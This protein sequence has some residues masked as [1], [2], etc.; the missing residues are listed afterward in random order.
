MNKKDKSVW[1]YFYRKAGGR[2]EEDAAPEM[3]CM[4]EEI[5]PLK[6]VHL[7][8]KAQAVMLFEQG[9]IK[10][11]HGIAILTA[12]KEMDDKGYENVREQTG[13]GGHSG[14]AFLI[15]KLGMETGGQ[16]HIGR[17]SAD[18]IAVAIRV[19]QRDRIIDILNQIIILNKTLIKLSKN[20]LESVIPAYTHFQQAQPITLAH[21]CMSWI[22]AFIRDFDR[23]LEI[24]PR[25]NTS[26]A[27]AAIVSGSPLP[28]NRERVAELIG[29]NT[30][31]PNT[32]DAIF[33]YDHHLEL[34]SKLAVLNNGLARFCSD[35]YIWSSFEFD[36]VEL[37]DRF[38]GTSS[39]NPCKKNPQA[40]EQI[41]SLA[42][43]A[44]GNMMTAFAVDRIPSESWEIQWRVW[45]Q[46]FW[47][48]LEKTIQGLILVN[49]VVENLEIK[50]E[51]MAELVNA[52]WATSSDLAVAIVREKE[53]PWRIAHQIVANLVRQCTKQKIR[54]QE[55][56]TELLDKVAEERIGEKLHLKQ[57]I[58]RKALNPL[59]CVKER[60]LT[61]GCAPEEVTRQIHECS[62]ILKK[63]EKEVDEIRN[64]LNI[65][66][67]KLDDAVAEIINK[68]K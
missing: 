52:G 26:P 43:S 67:Q 21:Y 28:V 14:E 58:I 47:P 16:I 17:S 66:T 53:L 31:I 68:K 3:T 10:P 60:R 59:E 37:K 42:A 64:A 24:Y 29:F 30:V 63:N 20:H 62:T 7:F 38:C 44:T 41:F 15:D 4:R 40:L 34:F 49:S 56:N 51:R 8:D 65:S 57:E 22:Y 54:S 35:L 55:V 9:I 5:L 2:F 61:G 46:R 27:G 19:E 6:G 18:L 45:S 36:M 39:I 23:L 48:L 13:G 1:G 11:E 33:G 50:T 12:F 25:T 32:R